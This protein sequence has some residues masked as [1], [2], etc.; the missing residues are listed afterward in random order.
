MYGDFRWTLFELDLFAVPALFVVMVAFIGG[1][2]WQLRETL[3]SSIG[4][5]RIVLW[6]WLLMLTA[7]FLVLAIV[8][9]G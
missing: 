8:A 9:G 7:W 6:S 3:R 4:Y 1:A 5:K 2:R